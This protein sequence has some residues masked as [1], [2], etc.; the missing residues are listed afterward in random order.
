MIF[1]CLL[2]SAEFFITISGTET[3]PYRWRLKDSSN[4][5][6][7]SKH[8]NPWGQPVFLIIRST[9]DKTFNAIYRF[10]LQ[11]VDKPLDDEFIDCDLFLREVSGLP[12]FTGF[13]F[14]VF[15]VKVPSPIKS[16]LQLILAAKTVRVESPPENQPPKTTPVAQ[17]KPEQSD[18]GDFS[19]R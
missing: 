8:P 11:V 12:S 3:W 1:H 4:L 10:D 15:T 7:Y 13:N 18:Q 9:R 19:R 14:G 17:S 2:P 5:Q 6:I 16:G